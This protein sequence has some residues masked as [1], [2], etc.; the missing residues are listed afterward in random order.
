MHLLRIETVHSLPGRIRI[1]INGLRGN[2]PFAASLAKTLRRHDHIYYVKANSQTGKAL[3]LFDKNALSQ[4]DL[5]LKVK[6]DIYY[7]LQKVAAIDVKQKWMQGRTMLKRKN[8][9]FEP[10]DIPLGYQVAQVV[11]TGGILLG[12]MLKRCFFKK[13]LTASSVKLNL[14]AG[15]TT[16]VAGYPIIRSGLETLVTRKKLNNDL[17]ISTVTIVSLLLRE[18]ITGLVVVWLV[19]LSTLFQTLTLEKS[20]KAIREMLQGKEENAWIE[21]D[22]TVI[23][24]P[25][26]NVEVGNTVLCF[27]GDRVPID[28]EVIGGEAT[29]SQAIITGESLPVLKTPGDRVYA[30]SIVEQGSIKIL[31]EKA[32]QDTSVAKIVAMVEEASG[33]R[34]PIESMAV[35]YAERIVPYSFGLAALVY[36]LT[37]DY[38]RSMTMLVIACPCA[39]GLATPTAISASMG[40]AARQGILIKGGGYLEKVGKTDV[41]LFDKTGTL[42]EGKPSVRE[43]LPMQ[44]TI[45]AE[46]ILQLAASI[47]YQTNHPLA[48]AVVKKAA[49]MQLDLL[50]VDNKEVIIGQGVKGTMNNIPVAIGNM[51]LMNAGR[52]NVARAKAKTYRL[53]MLGQTVLYVVK[54]QRLIGLIGIADNI[55]TDSVIAIRK[56]RQVGVK[57][58]GLVSGDCRETAELVAQELGLNKVWSET[59]P[60]GKVSIVKEFQQAHQTVA[61]VGDGIND[62]PALANA[63]IGIAMGTGGTDVA[64]E[65][66]HIVLAADDPVKIA[67]LISL[68]QHTMEII[69]QNFIFAVG[70]NVMGLILGAGKI[71]SP[72]TAAIIHNLSTFGVVVNSSRLFHFKHDSGK[73]RRTRGGIK[74]A[75]K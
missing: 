39:A 66:A 49:Q 68:S 34:A 65:S 43:I 36:L 33:K 35:R 38:K 69:K 48:N 22:N 55:R 56:L 70:I 64:I 20:R 37:R 50:K 19:N 29:V 14:L 18:N 12:L 45:P 27:I 72:L 61:M 63:D 21:V 42:T 13:S 17:L 46:Q 26:E 40:N 25:V 59:M 75:G 10:E 52:V 24:I 53:N 3:I 23:S 57:N 62:S 47:E 67:S 44:K 16:I 11:I 74:R 51:A 2:R 5:I 15:L 8:E 41:V 54:E 31:V 71:I 4:E 73:G 60:A 28:G 6:K 1:S 30:G 9:A 7:I 58:I 32:G